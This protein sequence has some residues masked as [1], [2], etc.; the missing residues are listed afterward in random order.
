MTLHN[1]SARIKVMTRGS[2]APRPERDW[3][4]L[5]S[6]GGVALIIIFAWQWWVFERVV[7]GEF[8]D[9]GVEGTMQEGGRADTPEDQL[10]TFYEARALEEQKYTT[11][12]YRLADPSQ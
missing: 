3:Q 10:Q 12:V 9:S 7:H 1:L 6:I 11:G 2:H 8:R 5:L 4:L